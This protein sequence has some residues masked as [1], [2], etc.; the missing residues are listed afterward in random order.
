MNEFLQLF[1]Q[2]HGAGLAIGIKVALYGGMTPNDK[3]EK[4]A[5]KAIAIKG[6]GDAA[7][8]GDAP[9]TIIAKGT[10]DLAERLLDIA[11]TKGIKVRQDKDLTELL[12]AFDVES[13]IPLEALHAVSLILERVYAEN[14]RLAGAGDLGDIVST[15]PVKETATLDGD[16]GEPLP[17]DDD[18]DLALKEGQPDG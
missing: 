6:G 7:G 4:P 14:Q 5:T 18:E 17:L 10:G 15:G 13:P 9:P 1:L 16:T 3:S 11:F 12:D 8:Q 2:N